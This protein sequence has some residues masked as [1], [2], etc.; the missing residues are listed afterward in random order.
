VTPPGDDTP[1]ESV[2]RTGGD[3]YR[4][5]DGLLRRL[6][7]ARTGRILVRPDSHVASAEA[8]PT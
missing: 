2:I 6:L 5:R 4:E 8:A 1:T 3:G 7:G